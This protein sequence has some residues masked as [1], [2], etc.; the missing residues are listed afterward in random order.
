MNPWHNVNTGKESPATVNAIV[1]IPMG[2]TAKYEMD[3]ETGL[4]R[5]DRVLYS[6]FYYPANYGFIAQTYGDDNDPL[7]ILVLSQIA[8]VPLCIVEAKVIGVM[9]MMDSGEGDDKIIAVAAKDMSVNY[10]NEITDLPKHFFQELRQFFEQYKK[11]ENKTVVVE[12][13]QSRQEAYKIIERSISQY[14][15]K[16][17]K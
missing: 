13:F 4:I 16:F 14:K 12:D 1:E 2:G 5:L 6:A 3:K 17:P 10:I 11:L 15:A 9:R 7:D 8:V